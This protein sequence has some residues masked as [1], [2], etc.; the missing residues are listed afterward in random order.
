MI[1]LSIPEIANQI[2]PALLPYLPYLLKGAQKVTDLATDMGR[3]LG[4]IEWDT[5]LKI[6][7][8]LRPHVEK[9]PEV[10]Q[11]LKKVAERKDENLLAW[12]LEKVLEQLSQLELQQISDLTQ[13]MRSETRITTASGDRS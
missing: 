2:G 7:E 4:K 3:N 5:L 11:Q 12:E 10:E 8:K 6:W 9:Q 13:Q 1:A